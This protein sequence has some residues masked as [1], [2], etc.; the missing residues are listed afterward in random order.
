MSAIVEDNNSISKFILKIYNKIMSN[1]LLYLY[2]DLYTFIL[3]R[4][5]YI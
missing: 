5:I 3:F 2:T 1:K 4:N